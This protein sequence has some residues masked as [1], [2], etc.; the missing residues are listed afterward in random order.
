[1]VDGNDDKLLYRLVCPLRAHDVNTVSLE[2]SK[3]CI[4]ILENGAEVSNLARFLYN[5]FY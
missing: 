1:M 4:D 5:R 3:L 2:E